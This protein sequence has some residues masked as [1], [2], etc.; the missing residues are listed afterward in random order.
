MNRAIA[1]A[2]GTLLALLAGGAGAAPLFAPVAV[3]AHVYDGGW[4]HFVGGGLAVFDCDSDGLPE[5]FAAGG[6]NPPTLLRN[7][8]TRGGDLA[9]L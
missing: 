6:E 7:R 1:Q 9:F 3:P 5:L 4:A 2:L 8:A